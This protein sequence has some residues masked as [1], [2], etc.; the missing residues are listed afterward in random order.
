M[1]IMCHFQQMP[2]VLEPK[3]KFKYNQV[4]KDPR[5]ERPSRSLEVVEL[6]WAGWVMD[7]DDD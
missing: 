7:G 3:V 1:T 2:C 5:G 4:S 6:K